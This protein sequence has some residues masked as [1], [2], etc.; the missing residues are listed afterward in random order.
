M[1]IVVGGSGDD[2]GTIATLR[3]G[4]RVAVALVLALSGCG[5]GHPSLASV[6][7]DLMQDYIEPLRD[8][9]FAVTVL[10]ACH[11]P[12]K[13]DDEPWH[14]D[15]R[16]AIGAGPE[17]VVSVLGGTVEV[18]NQHGM[19]WD[20][21]QIAGRPQAGWTGLVRGGSN[22]SRLGVVR[23]NVDPRGTGTFGWNQVCDLGAMP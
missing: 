15:M 8:A 4:I 17:Q 9:G 22:G 21:Q 12:P 16:M 6:E 20:L 5:G 23:N 19:Q 10:S 11:Y 7:R 1:A 13:R 18:I 3:R 2:G 14:L